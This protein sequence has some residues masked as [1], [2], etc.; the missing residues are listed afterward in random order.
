MTRKITISLP[1]ELDEALALAALRRKEAKSAVI[2][3]FLRE[4][5]EVAKYVAVVRSEPD[6]TVFTASSRARRLPKALK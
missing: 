5:K 6:T 1:D 4:H 2:A 3:T